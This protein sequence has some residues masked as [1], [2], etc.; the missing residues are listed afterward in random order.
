M[1]FPLAYSDLED[2]SQFFELCNR[3]RTLVQ[4]DQS[5]TQYFSSLKRLWQEL[6]LFNRHDWRDVADARVFQRLME[7]RIYDFLAGLN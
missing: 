4:G 5:V 2:S 7:E 1:L 3:T 6:D